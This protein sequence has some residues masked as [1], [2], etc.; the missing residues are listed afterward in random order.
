[1]NKHDKRKSKEREQKRKKELKEH[2]EKEKALQ[3]I[4]KSVS[5]EI[6]KSFLIPKCSRCNDINF[7]FIQ[8][9][10]QL[11]GIKF[12]CK[13]CNRT[14]WIKAE[15]SISKSIYDEYIEYRELTFNLKPIILI[16]NYNINNSSQDRHHIPSSVKHEV[17]NR[18]GGKCVKCGSCKD[19]EYDH[20]I[21]V[22]KGG[23]NTVR[24]I[25]LLCEK[26]NRKKATNIE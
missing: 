20:I 14:C 15:Q 23:S 22:S 12:E 4:K 5:E 21:P 2:E 25:Q 16:S 13:T 9:N 6:K 11:D 19:L 18:D 8:F 1:M 24:N 26:C 10:T 7:K 17:W 3:K